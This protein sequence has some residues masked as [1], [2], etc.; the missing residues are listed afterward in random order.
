MRSLPPLSRIQE[1]ALTKLLM[2]TSK[3]EEIHCKKVHQTACTSIFLIQLNLF[4][5]GHLPIRTSNRDLMGTST[6][7]SR[8]IS[9][10]FW[11]H[12]I[13]PLPNKM[14]TLTCYIV[15]G[16]G[17][18]AEGWLSEIC[19]P[20]QKS[21]A[22]VPFLVTVLLQGNFQMFRCH[23]NIVPK[24]AMHNLVICYFIL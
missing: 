22:P 23:A 7:K 16:C 18:I 4:L 3:K 13:P 5:N 15:L 17:G 6:P 10:R 8:W 24:T 20:T 21:L 2:V 12:F 19:T 11:V 9:I 14:L 1:A